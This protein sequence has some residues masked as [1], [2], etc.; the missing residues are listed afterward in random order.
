[1]FIHSQHYQV[2]YW[3][4]VLHLPESHEQYI[5]PSGLIIEPSRCSCIRK[6]YWSI[7]RLVSNLAWHHSQAL[8]WWT[9][10][11]NL[12]YKYCTPQDDDRVGRVACAVGSWALV[13]PGSYEE[14]RS[15]PFGKA[16]GG[17]WWKWTLTRMAPCEEDQRLPCGCLLSTSS[18]EPTGYPG[19]L[20]LSLPL[21][22]FL[23][24]VPPGR[25]AGRGSWP[26]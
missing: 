12:K 9:Q 23:F 14:E 10:V 16:Q 3:A 11:R 5:Q 7:S 1:M 21:S 20:L 25:K 8:N 26:W 15:F 4:T 6:F 13:Q 18:P 22:T 19:T 24:L 17:W 2:K